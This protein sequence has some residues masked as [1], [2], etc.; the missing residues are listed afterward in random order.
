M[1]SWDIGNKKLQIDYNLYYLPHRPPWNSSSRQ[2]VIYK[3]IAHGFIIPV[4]FL[5]HFN[6]LLQSFLI[7]VLVM[8][9][10]FSNL[11]IHVLCP[12]VL[13]NIAFFVTTVQKDAILVLCIKV[14][15]YELVGTE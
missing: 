13:A 1:F 15:T 3:A 6:F 10:H 14:L 12:H 8:Y 5:K 4:S 9:I 2:N 7:S 11:H